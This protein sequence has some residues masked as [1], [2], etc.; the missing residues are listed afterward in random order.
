MLM[1]FSWLKDVEKRFASDHT[2]F[3][4]GGLPDVEDDREEPVFDKAKKRAKDT[5]EPVMVHVI[6]REKRGEIGSLPWA[7]VEPDGTIEYA[8]PSA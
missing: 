7:L 8:Y 1:R 5:N 2:R 6:L 4:A 3:R